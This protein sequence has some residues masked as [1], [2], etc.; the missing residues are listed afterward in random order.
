MCVA[1]NNRYASSSAD[2]LVSRFAAVDALR[3]VAILAI[4]CFYLHGVLT[5]HGRT[6][7]FGPVLD[8]LCLQ[9]EHGVEI[10]FVLSGFVIAHALHSQRLRAPVAGRFLLRRFVRL[11]PAYWAVLF[12]GFAVGTVANR[13][14]LA[15]RPGMSVRAVLVNMFCLQDIWPVYTPLSAAWSLCAEIQFYLFFILLLWAFQGLSKW[16]PRPLARHVVFVPPAVA[17]F[18]LAAGHGP[19]LRGIHLDHWHLFFLGT[20]AYWTLMGVISAIW[21]WIYVAAMLLLCNGQILG[22]SARGWRFTRSHCWACWIPRR[23]RAFWPGSAA[24]LTAFI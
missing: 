13:S 4:V 21:F 9:G 22:A 12:V 6:A 7:L 14:D 2:S 20:V 1:I 11:G 10:F 8:W 15:G 17:S 5:H 18:L 19:L 24:A 3:G 16:L 23:P